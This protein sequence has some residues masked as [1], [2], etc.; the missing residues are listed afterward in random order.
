MFDD[1]LECRTRH[2]DELHDGKAKDAAGWPVYNCRPTEFKSV[3][4]FEATVQEAT[5]IW[6]VIYVL[7]MHT[8]GGTARHTTF[9][10]PPLAPW[11][12]FLLT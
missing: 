9:S 7:A 2:I 3:E 12:L 4:F 8:S 1:A 11:R 5:L 10:A 6:D